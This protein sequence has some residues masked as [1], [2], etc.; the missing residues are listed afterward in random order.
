MDNKTIKRLIQ[1]YSAAQLQELIL[2][3]ADNNHPAQQALLEYCQKKGKTQKPEDYSTVIVNQLEHHWTRASE[4]IDEF[5]EYGGGPEDEEDIAYD[6]LEKM[7]E[8]LETEEIPWEPRRELLEEVLDFVRM[9]N[10]GFS[11][12]L[13]DVASSLCRTKEEKIYL[14]DYLSQSASYYGDLAAEIYRAYGEDAKYL[15]Y[16]KAHLNYSQDYLDLAK[17]YEKHG[18]S[19]QALQIVQEAYRKIDGRLDEIYRYL[20]QYYVKHNDRKALEELYRDSMKKGRDQDTITELM[21]GY[22]KEKGEYEKQKATL[23]RLLSCA[24]TGRWR[25]NRGGLYK[26]YRQCRQELTSEDFDKEEKGILK[27]I[28]ERDISAYFDI[29]I[30]KNEMKEVMDYIL[31]SGQYGG[32]GLDQG[33]YF[34]K[35][36]SGQYPR[37]IVELYWKE[38]ASYV[39]MG[40]EANYARA[41]S[42]LK[43]I[44][45]IMKSNKW[46]DEWK[47]RYQAFLEEHRRKKLLLRL[48]EGFKA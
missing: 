18:D 46:T 36:L 1:N 15:E 5:N 23:L 34:T 43:E 38:T 44:R 14:A 32:Y 42:V 28:K 7:T 33:H 13:M 26:L 8:I 11:D 16:K 19:G 29:L 20:F 47:T 39:N 48:L 17:Y 41:V 27:T 2:A 25:G 45:Q 40:K 37:E 9:D 10:S 35:R 12:T 24:D 3:I 4:I 6:E 22:Y 30:E 21:H 31:H